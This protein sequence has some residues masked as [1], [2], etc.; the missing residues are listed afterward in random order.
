MFL[1]SPVKSHSFNYSV[2]KIYTHLCPWYLE[3]C[4]NVHQE[5]CSYNFCLG[6]FYVVL[7][8]RL[9]YLV[10]Q[11]ICESSIVLGGCVTPQKYTHKQYIFCR[12]KG[13]KNHLTFSK[14]LLGLEIE[15]L[16]ETLL[17]MESKWNGNTIYYNE[18]D[19]SSFSQCRFMDCAFTWSAWHLNLSKFSGL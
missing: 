15:K 18:T 7:F 10:K 8:L 13:K 4:R 12:R 5:T 19:V 16:L 6:N 1:L 14:M 11:R 9:F 2:Y 3:L 17:R